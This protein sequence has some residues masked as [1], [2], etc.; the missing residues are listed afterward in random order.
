[1]KALLHRLD[2]IERKREATKPPRPCLVVMSNED[3]ETKT[4]EF[5]RTHGFMPER[6]FVIKRAPAPPRP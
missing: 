4:A 6:I 3:P 5:R 2:V 1:M